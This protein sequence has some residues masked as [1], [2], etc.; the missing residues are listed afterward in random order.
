[1]KETVQIPDGVPKS[2]RVWKVKQTARSSAQLKKGI[3]SHLSKTYEEREIERQK[4]RNVKELEQE[5]IEDKKQKKLEEKLRRE[6]QEKRR[7]ENEYKNSIT[8]EVRN[9]TS[10]FSKF[11]GLSYHSL[12]LF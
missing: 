8:Q 9:R 12:F 3:L 4:R 7:Q 2:G 5:M 6:A 11:S 10:N 1:M